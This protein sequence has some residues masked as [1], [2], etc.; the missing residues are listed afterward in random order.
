VYDALT[1]HRPYRPAWSHEQAIQYIREQA[2]KHFDPS[3]VPVFLHL[4]GGG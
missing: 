1:N 3:L 2:G 4:A